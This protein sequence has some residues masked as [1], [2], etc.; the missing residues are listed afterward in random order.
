MR[1][2]NEHTLEQRTAESA[3]VLNKYPDRIPV[4][5]E[6]SNKCKLEALDKKKYL[7]PDDLTCGQF[8]YVIRKRLRLPAEKAIFLFVGGVIPPSSQQMRVLYDYNKDRDGFLY[9]Q[10][11]EE[12]VFG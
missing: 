9:I 5:C 7:V 8:V 4:I 10:Y 1:F 11:S 2:K 12:N 3:R 6:E